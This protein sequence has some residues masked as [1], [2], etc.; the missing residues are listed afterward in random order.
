MS[1]AD[2]RNTKGLSTNWWHSILRQYGLA[3]IAVAAA[4]TLRE[5][6]IHFFGFPDSFV[7]FDPAILIVAFA[8]GVRA[9]VVRDLAVGRDCRVLPGTG[10]FV[11]GL[12]RWRNRSPMP[13]IATP[14]TPNSTSA[15]TSPA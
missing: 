15:A 12:V 7:L 9:R 14:T 2:R 4:L 13:L 11:Q 6:L 8:R 3:L 1:S 5:G 10:E